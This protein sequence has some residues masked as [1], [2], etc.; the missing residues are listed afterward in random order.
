[1]GTIQKKFTFFVASGLKKKIELDLDN[2]EF[3]SVVKM[4]VKKLI[5]MIKAGKIADSKT[6]CAVMVYAAKKKLL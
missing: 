1:M 5:G 4:D 3:I 6:I 2:D